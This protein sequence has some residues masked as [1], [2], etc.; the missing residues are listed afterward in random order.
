MATLTANDPPVDRDSLEYLRYIYEHDP[1]EYFAIIRAK[2][3]FIQTARARHLG[4][5]TDVKT[6]Q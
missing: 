5:F 2:Y 1:L 4:N 3:D 6:D